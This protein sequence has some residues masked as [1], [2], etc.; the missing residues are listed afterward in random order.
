MHSV[1]SLLLFYYGLASL[2][3]KM[4]VYFHVVWTWTTDFWCVLTH[5]H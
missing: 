1:E 4:K 5:N 3:V 2:P